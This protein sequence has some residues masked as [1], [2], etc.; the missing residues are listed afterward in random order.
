VRRRSSFAV[1]AAL[2]SGVA[3]LLA[4]ATPVTAAAP[5]NAFWTPIGPYGGVVVAL[6]A[7]PSSPEILYAGVD[8][9][10]VYRSEDAGL[11]W[12][13][14]NGGLPDLNVAALAVSPANANMILAGAVSGL[15]VSTDGG[16]T[17]SLAAGSP[18]TIV[19]SIV[20]DPVDATIAYAASSSG[21]V[22]RSTDAGRSWTQIGADVAGQQPT[23][24]AIAP[25][26]HTTLYLG[27][28]LN[29]VYRSIDSGATWTAKVNGLTNLHVSALGI[30]P[31]NAQVVF[32]GTIGGGIFLTTDGGEN[33]ASVDSPI[34]GGV[35]AMI[36]D[37]AGTV[38]A[39][40][41]A[42]TWALPRGASQWSAVGSIPVTPTGQW[43]NALA[44]GAGSPQHLFLG[45]GSLPFSPGGVARVD[46]GTT[47]ILINGMTGITVN[48]FSYDA[49]ISALLVG[50]VAYGLF[51]YQGG[52]LQP[53]GLGA[54]IL[55]V[56]VVPPPNE[57]W[58]AGTTFGVYKSTDEGANWTSVSNG[59]PTNPATPVASLLIPSG[60]GAFL[61]GT[62][63]GLYSSSDSAASWTQVT[64]G[65]TAQVI[66]SL[67]SD[68]ASSGVVYAGTEQGV[69]Q[70]TNGGA[71]WAATGPGITGNLVYDV[72]VVGGAVFAAGEGGVFR[73]TSGGASWE[74]LSGGL[75]SAAAHA[76]VYDA[77]SSTLYAGTYAGVWQSTDFG[78][79]W[80]RVA[81]G[82]ANPQ[83]LALAVLPGGGL[84]AGTLAGSAY[85][86]ATPEP[87][88]PVQRPPVRSGGTRTLPA[89]P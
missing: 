17:W 10:G 6:A 43:I 24:I 49:D 75:P 83:I 71:A 35:S 14:V 1:V 56:V 28:N 61:A 78:T 38:Y 85:V 81:T 52:P 20:F 62:Y 68:P 63:H 66:Y 7:F 80:T 31:D 2:L 13:P 55:D 79:T 69:F 42:G 23:S 22:G 8:H 5:V 60:G 33:W 15:S 21:W 3:M 54:S 47:A 36:V 88:E 82:P 34:S 86:L 76:I 32:A 25:S 39:A 50:T 84:A 18:G 64:T 41:N 72:L 51:T 40:N 44:L 53:A 11:H 48:A 57:A 27:T 30:D 45:Y 70:S 12:R 87:R 4:A 46:G 19:G 16:A 74:P 58:Y 77:A 26:L 59:I 9:G 73:S 67:A 29:G 65:L 89:R 37:A